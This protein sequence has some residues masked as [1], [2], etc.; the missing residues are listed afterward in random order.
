MTHELKTW[1]EYFE[2]ILN[3]EKNFEV[4]A[5][6]RN[7]KQGDILRLNEYDPEQGDYTGRCILRKVCFV[8]YGGKFDIKSGYCVMSIS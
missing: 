8:L 6:D 7:F 1:P 4:R 3:N 2:K 5:N